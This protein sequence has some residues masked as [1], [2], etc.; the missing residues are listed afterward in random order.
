M[1]DANALIVYGTCP[2]RHAETLARVLVDAHLAA[3]VNI[4]PG[5][6]SIFRWKGR[7]QQDT[8]SL[9]IIK[10]TQARYPDLEKAWRDRHPY[11]LPEL[12]AVPVAAGSPDYLSWL[13]TSTL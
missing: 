2:E 5:I 6:R 4:V 9:L 8:E 3:C 13:E 11:E 10:T 1:S 7:V 12:L